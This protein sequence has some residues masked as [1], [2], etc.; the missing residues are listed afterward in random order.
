VCVCACVCVCV[1]VCVCIVRERWCLIGLQV[2]A[3]FAL[4]ALHLLCCSETHF[5]V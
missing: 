3:V 4:F 5:V 2:R 1:C